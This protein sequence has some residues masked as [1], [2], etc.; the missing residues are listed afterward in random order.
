MWLSLTIIEFTI[1]TGMTANGGMLCDYINKRCCTTNTVT[2]N[3]LWFVCDNVG[4]II[5]LVGGGW[6]VQVNASFWN[7]QK[8]FYKIMKYIFFCFRCLVSHMLGY[9]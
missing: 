4:A 9:Q 5:G 8:S 1:F 2:A 3:V 7:D 6:L